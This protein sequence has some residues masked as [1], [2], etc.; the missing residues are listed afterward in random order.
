M[1]PK[2]RDVL[3]KYANWDPAA[4]VLGGVDKDC[5]G[6][7]ACSGEG[8]GGCSGGTCSGS[9]S[10]CGGCTNPFRPGGRLEGI[11]GIIRRP[12]VKG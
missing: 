7:G 1:S 6:C 11:R 5:S 9:C 3:E 12:K 8:G 4:P 10:Q 2:E